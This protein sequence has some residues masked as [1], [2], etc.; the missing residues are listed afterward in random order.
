MI[1]GDVGLRGTDVPLLQRI[2]RERRDV[3]RIGVRVFRWKCQELSIKRPCQADASAFLAQSSFWSA[4]SRHDKG[5]ARSGAALK[6]H[7]TAVG[8]PCGAANGSASLGNPERLFR[9]YELH[10]STY[11]LSCVRG[12]HEGDLL[13]VR[14]KCRIELRTQKTR[15]RNNPH[16]GHSVDGG[17][18]GRNVHVPARHVDCRYHRCRSDE[19]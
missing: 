13:T 10:V 6:S 8:R 7:V 19:R 1:A 2:Q 4:E 18:G 16:R 15:E 3:P 12:P 9:T 5:A 14:R 17:A 11:I